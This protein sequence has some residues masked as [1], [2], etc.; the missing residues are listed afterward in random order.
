MI[1]DDVFRSDRLEGLPGSAAQPSTASRGLPEWA[2]ARAVTQPEFRDNGH[3]VSPQYNE[4]GVPQDVLL[5]EIPASLEMIPAKPMVGALLTFSLGRG[6][7]TIDMDAGDDRQEN[8]SFACFWAR[9]GG[10]P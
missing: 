1:L 3:H 9:P 7:V 6:S 2:P 10:L 4:A 8:V 5:P